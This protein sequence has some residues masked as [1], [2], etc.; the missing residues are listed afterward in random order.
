MQIEGCRS[1]FHSKE[2]KDNVILILR[3][4]HALRYSILLVLYFN[5]HTRCPAIF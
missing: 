5:S 3:F 2:Q 1:L 4:L